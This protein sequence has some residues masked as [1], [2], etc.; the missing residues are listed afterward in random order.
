MLLKK[1]ITAVRSPFGCPAMRT[2]LSFNAAS[3]GETGSSDSLAT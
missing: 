2:G 1:S 3:S